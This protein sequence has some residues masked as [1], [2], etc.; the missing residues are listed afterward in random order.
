MPPEP[1]PVVSYA[2]QIVKS[3][4]SYTYYR[5][6]I[7]SPCPLSGVQTQATN[8]YDAYI[9]PAMHKT[10][11]PDSHTPHTHR[12]AIQGQRCKKDG[13]L[14]KIAGDRPPR[15]R[16]SVGLLGLAQNIRRM[17]LDGL[18]R[19]KQRLGYLFIRVSASQ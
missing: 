11:T 1:H 18:D 17:R 4:I 8:S 3:R 15:E 12:V 9:V 7:K 14:I 2:F 19:N 10:N 16:M 6:L 13:K 5:I